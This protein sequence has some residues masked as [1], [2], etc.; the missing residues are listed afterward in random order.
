M[1]KSNLKLLA[2]LLAVGLL[3]LCGSALWQRK[4]APP[5]AATRQIIR[6]QDSMHP[7]IR[8]DR[9]GKCTLCGMDLTP[10]YGGD[11]G[12]EVSGNMA[13]LSSNS[14]T[15]LNVQSEEVQR[16]SLFRSLRV[17]GIL[18]ANETRKAVVSAPLAC[19]IQNMLVEHAGVEV[20]EGEP[21]VT[22]FSPEFGQQRAYLRAVGINLVAPATNPEQMAHNTDPFSAQ[23]VAPL[24]GVVTERNVYNGQYA[25]QGEKLMTI[26][27]P[28]VLWFRFDVY[29]RQLP[30]FA[31]GQTVTVSV[32]AV[33]GRTF[34][35]PIVFID[36]TVD[37]AT[38]TVKVRVD[39]PN[40]VIA[41]NPYPQRLLRF[42]VYAEGHVQS[43]VPAVLVV[44]VPAVLFPGGTAYAYVE[45]GHGVYE[46][47]KLRLGRQGDNGWEVLGGLTPGDRVVTSGNVLLDAQAQFSQSGQTGAANADEPEERAAVDGAREM[48]PAC[49]PADAIVPP[50]API[51]LAPATA[52]GAPPSAATHANAPRRRNAQLS[53][54]EVDQVRMAV[55]ED[56]WKMRLAAMAQAQGTNVAQP[57]AEARPAPMEQRQI[58]DTFFTAACAVGQ[59][60]AADDLKMFNAQAA[61]L[62][63]AVSRLRLAF[64]EPHPLAGSISALD[65]LSHGAPAQTLAAAR[66]RFLAF[67]TPLVAFAQLARRSDPAC[68]GLKIYHCPMAPQPGLWLQIKGPLANPFFGG[69]MPTCGEEVSNDTP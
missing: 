5:P 49:K 16:R 69:Q 44:P 54:Y 10:I 4:L 7:W 17:A 60:L 27:D 23:L 20:R 48:P 12:F 38:R 57:L 1:M 65:D 37:D 47:R 62:P 42:G 11:N 50:L 26:V 55:K 67:S 21:L 29:E 6:Y 22:I 51:D 13:V 39:I 35:A 3:G 33:P 34:A 2:L 56:M 31:L 59:A 30:W 19:R 8:S 63:A 52:S 15:V 18:E 9:P 24:S 41:T 58:L 32:P 40:P 25:A 36:P 66:Q 68:A 28:S 45:R 14:V 53:H 61:A 46:R 64:A 43:V